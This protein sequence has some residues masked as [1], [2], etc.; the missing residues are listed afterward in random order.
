V[1]SD[2]LQI[3]RGHEFIA[4][5]TH[6]SC[7]RIGWSGTVSFPLVHGS[8][9]TACAPLN[10]AHNNVTVNT[11]SEL[12]LMIVTFLFRQH[13]VAALLPVFGQ[14]AVLAQI[15]KVQPQFAQG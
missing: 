9:S 14:I 5:S 13:L 6:T 3:A 4:Y 8:G 1:R 11:A 2:Q 7:L 12:I 10:D 15:P